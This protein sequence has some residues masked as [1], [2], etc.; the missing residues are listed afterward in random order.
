MFNV[1]RTGARLRARAAGRWFKNAPTGR[2]SAA[3]L[4][5][6]KHFQTNLKLTD[7]LPPRISR[8]VRFN[9][10]K[11]QRVNLETGGRR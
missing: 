9:E 1:G 6:F 4:N 2:K 7:V 10:A 8:F 11:T 5:L 3:F